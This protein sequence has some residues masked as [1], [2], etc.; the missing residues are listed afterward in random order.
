MVNRAVV[1]VSVLLSTAHN[2]IK[3]PLLNYC[4]Q[5][6]RKTNMSARAANHSLNPARILVGIPGGF[7]CVI[8]GGFMVVYQVRLVDRLDR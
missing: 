8:P 2:N 7:P 1:V 4:H 6:C 3:C 5:N